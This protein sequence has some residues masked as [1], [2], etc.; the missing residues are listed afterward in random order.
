MS[1]VNFRWW[2][3]FRF[4]EKRKYRVVLRTK[5]GGFDRTKNEFSRAAVW[6]HPACG[7]V[8]APGEFPCTLMPGNPGLEQRDQGR[9]RNGLC[10]AIQRLA[11]PLR[12]S[13]RGSQLMQINCGNGFCDVELGT[14]S[15]PPNSF[16]TDQ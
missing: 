10:R 12:L 1:R 5:R 15:R 16:H 11:R 9:E 8:T 7:A 4:L 14:G 2:L 6:I 3:E 13:T